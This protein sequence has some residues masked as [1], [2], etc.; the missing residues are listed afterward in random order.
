MS[1]NSTGRNPTDTALVSYITSSASFFFRSL[2]CP[3]A[4]AICG[5]LNWE[6]KLSAPIR[7]PRRN[8]TLLSRTTR[9]IV[10]RDG[11]ERAGK[12]IVFG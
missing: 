6:R 10:Y 8:G 1:F 3:V 12:E 7:R 9:S 11:Y 4:V 2:N 5:E